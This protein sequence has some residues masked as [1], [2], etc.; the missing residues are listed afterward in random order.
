ME[1]DKRNHGYVD[2][3]DALEA[4]CNIIFMMWPQERLG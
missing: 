3:A 1:L 4:S 2:M